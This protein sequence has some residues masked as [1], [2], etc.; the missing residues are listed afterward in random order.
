ME[1]LDQ[2]KKSSLF[3]LI[4]QQADV[5]KIYLYSIDPYKTK[6]Q[7]LISKQ[8]STSLKHFIDSKSYIEYSNDMDDIYKTLKNTTQLKNVKY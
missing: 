2:E 8:E 4:N 6:Y 5:D 3:N 7:F 1:G